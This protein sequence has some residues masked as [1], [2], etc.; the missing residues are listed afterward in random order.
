MKVPLNLGARWRW[1]IT[2]TSLP[3]Y[4][5]ERTPESI[6]HEVVWAPEPVWTIR[7][8]ENFF[9]SAGIRA[10]DRL[11]RSLVT[12]PTDSQL[13]VIHETLPVCITFCS[14]SRN[15]W[16]VRERTGDARI[17]ACQPARWHR[18]VTDAKVWVSVLTH[19]TVG[20]RCGC[21]C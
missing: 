19:S 9:T 20:V 16:H 3:P 10:P 11:A 5:R 18:S 8:I 7:W 2:F 4:L 17:A 13:Q 12:I 14:W 15:G 21:V 1:V 6:E